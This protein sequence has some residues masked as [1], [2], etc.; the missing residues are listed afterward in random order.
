VRIRQVDEVNPTGALFPSVAET[1]TNFELAHVLFMDVVG[2]SQ[3]LIDDQREVLRNLNAIVRGTDQFRAAEAQKKLVCLPTGDGMVI[4]FFTALDAAARCAIEIAR[5]LRDH[6]EIGLRM[7]IHCGPV[8][9]VT[10]VN[11]HMNIAGGGINMA[12][13]VMDCGD[14]GHILLSQR[15]AEDLAQVREW[16]ASVHDVGETDVK[17][18]TKLH[19]F[20]FFGD[21]FGNAAL[22]AKFKKPGVPA[23]NKKWALAALIAGVAVIALLLFYRLG[24]PLRGVPRSGERGPERGAPPV[25]DKSIAVLPFENLSDDKSN[26]YFVDG[27]QDEILT[28][29]AKVADLKVI[30][31]TSTQR[32]KSKP[33]DL[34]E[35]AKQL[36]VAHILEGSAQRSADQV[37]VN[38]QLIKAATDTH[39]WAE[40]Y[41]RKLTDVFGVETEIA[42]KVVDMLQARLTGAEHI[43]MAARPTED[44]EAHQL[45]LKGR[46]FWRKR[47]EDGFKN[48]L[49]YFQ[50]ALARDPNYALAY[51]GIADCYT[52][53][54][55]WRLASPAE[56]Y[57]KAK[58]AANKA[59]EIDE[60]LA[61]A[62]ASL[63]E[64]LSDGELNWRDA[65]RELERAIELNPNYATAH[66][67]IGIDVLAVLG[68][69]DDAIAEL[70][71]AVE[72]DPF[73][74]I[75]NTELGLCYI[76][77]RR[78]PEAVAQ[79]LRTVELEPGFSYAHST[80]GEALVLSDQLD[81][82]IGEYEKAY[83]ISHQDSQL[84][85]IAHAY[86]LKGE[87]EKS[88][89]LFNQAK[90]LSKP[91]VFAY[92]CALVSIGLGNQEEAISWL[93]QSY[94]QKE[95]VSISLI[96]VHP[97]LD[98]LR[99][100]P[101]FE[102]LAKK[103]VPPNVK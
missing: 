50:Q 92:G 31:R 102:A 103:I 76:V 38:V 42:T 97:F 17:H 70:K 88:L 8:S 35:I 32:F 87:R 80:L 51:A 100:N 67:W 47:T 21:G 34:P 54:A 40:T 6:P 95:G 98:P 43:A 74:P 10:D 72:L 25:S 85:R 9:A 61:E 60:S 64:V 3:M 96:K 78:Y 56:C 66:H 55:N 57:P 89:Q 33:G 71:R 39:L 30:S 23:A 94:L 82:A 18:G 15:V 27:I 73:S 79:L 36:G 59:L 49:S 4:A 45:Y 99:G 77:A 86:A 69:F 53:L 93:E 90:E 24:V 48:A 13:R 20:N 2:Y 29:L 22:P 7:G 14:A 19:L 62:H 63:G 11:Q 12:Q 83:N 65:R 84:M 1:A 16:N 75:I 28:R 52:L 5:A 91:A 37:R 81:R 46:Y 41:D 26:A 101:R 68:E 44:M 58:A